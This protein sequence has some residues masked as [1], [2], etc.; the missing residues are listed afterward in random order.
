MEPTRLDQATNYYKPL[1]RRGLPLPV[2]GPWDYEIGES[3]SSC[4]A[5]RTRPRTFQDQGGG[6]RSTSVGIIGNDVEMCT[7][8]VSS[9]HRLF[10]A[11]QSGPLGR[12]NRLLVS[13]RAESSIGPSAPPYVAQHGAEGRAA[14]ALVTPPLPSH[15]PVR[16]SGLF[17]RPGTAIQS[18]RR[19]KRR[20]LRRLAW[21]LTEWQ[22]TYFTY[23]AV[24]TPLDQQ[25][26]DKIASLRR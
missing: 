19:E 23:C 2:A 26:H 20:N 18:R 9:V 17:S 16:P 7:D 21:V 4:S 6:T 1:I 25:Q 8:F 11:L 10:S 15:L 22:V 24:G 12:C 14:R 5:P 3:P 13:M